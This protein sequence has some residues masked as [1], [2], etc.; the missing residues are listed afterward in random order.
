MR[1]RKLYEGNQILARKLNAR[2]VAP[3]GVIIGIVAV[4][5]ALLLIWKL[6][7]TISDSREFAKFEAER[8]NAKWDSGENPIYKEAKTTYRNPAYGGRM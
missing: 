1:F 8:Q 5:L 2:T 7:T 4:G 6:Y 3:L